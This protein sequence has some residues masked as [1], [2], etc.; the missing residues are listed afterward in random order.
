MKIKTPFIFFRRTD[1]LIS[2]LHVCTTA[3]V[4]WRKKHNPIYDFAKLEK[5][6]LLEW[7]I[8]AD[9]IRHKYD[10][11][12]VVSFGYLI[13]EDV[14]DCFPLY[15]LCINIVICGYPWDTVI[16][17]YNMFIFFYSGIL[18]VHG[19]VLPRW[20]GAAPIIRAIMN[21]DTET[22]VTIMKIS[23]RQWVNFFLKHV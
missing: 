18:N 20:R 14:I 3:S 23:P 4:D 9:Y 1:T 11:G 6:P 21:G 7:P 2:T 16:Y 10:I 19:S 12:I 15:D 17:I 5:L 8:E 13:P 22:G